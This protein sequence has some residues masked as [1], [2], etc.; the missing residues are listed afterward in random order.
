MTKKIKHC[1]HGKFNGTGETFFITADTLEGLKAKVN[2][3][4]HSPSYV[5]Y[6]TTESE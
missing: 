5:H 3:Q 6:G 1:A 4:M 2:G